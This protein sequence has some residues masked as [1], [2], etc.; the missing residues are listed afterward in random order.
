[1]KLR[2]FG[3][4]FIYGSDLNCQTSTWPALVAKFLDLEYVCHAVPGSGNLQIMESVFRYFQPG[5]ICVIGW[6]WIDRFDFIDVETE[7][8]QTLRPALDHEH[9]GYY[10]KNLHSQ[11]RDMLTNLCYIKATVD[12]LHRET[13]LMTAMDSLLFEKIQPSWHD[14]TAVSNLQHYVEPHIKNFQGQNFL[15]W[16]RNNNFEISQKWH[17]LEHAHRAAAD[18]IINHHLTVTNK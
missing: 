1:M 6:T 12:F 8:W 2:S 14:P 16:S 7:K 3:C 18:Y 15:D 4:S 13:Y 11:Y 9:A 5:D 17:P 10:Y